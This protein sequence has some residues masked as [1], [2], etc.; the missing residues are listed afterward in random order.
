[1]CAATGV[2]LCLLHGALSRLSRC[3]RE[4]AGLYG[5]VLNCSAGVQSATVSEPDL[6][7]HLL[8]Q[9]SLCSLMS[10]AYDTWG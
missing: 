10:C 7:F 2:Y 4:A 3:W 9:C 6:A 1:M 5:T 8:A